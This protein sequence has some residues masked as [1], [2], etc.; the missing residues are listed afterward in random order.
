MLLEKNEKEKNDLVNQI[1]EA[2][3]SDYKKQL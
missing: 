1:S 2:L 3:T